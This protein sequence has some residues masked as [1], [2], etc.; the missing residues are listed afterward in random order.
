[1]FLGSL[2]FVRVLLEVRSV[3]THFRNSYK[4]LSCE[5]K[6]LSYFETCLV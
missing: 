1:M 5:M 6:I 3:Y 2:S 4:L